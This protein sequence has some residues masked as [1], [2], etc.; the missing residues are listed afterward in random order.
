MFHKPE[1]ST[2]ARAFPC[3][4]ASCA[5]SLAGF[6][7]AVGYAQLNH[8]YVSFMSGN[9][10]HL[11][12][13]IAAGQWP[14]VV[15]AGSVIAA[16]VVGSFVGT[17]IAAATKKPLYALLLSEILLCIIAIGLAILETSTLALTVIALT[18]GMQNVMHRNVSGSDIG[19]SFITGALF[20][21]GQALA[22]VIRGEGAI[23][24]ALMHASSWLSFILGVVCGAISI[25]T[26]GLISS[27]ALVCAALIGLLAFALGA[28]SLE[29]SSER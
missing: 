13:A 6:L 3:V 20:G 25:D 5:T 17:L 22:Q 23:S 15:Y 18:M 4:Y 8:L 29:R 19:K 28:G 12:M 27:L 1:P 21:L 10:T 16:F 7:D 26:L 24:R 14:S 9:S 11:G 2:A